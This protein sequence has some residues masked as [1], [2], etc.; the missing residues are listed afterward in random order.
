MGRESNSFLPRFSVTR[1]ITVLMGL[2]A[3]LVVGF[4]AFT[5]IPVELFPAGFTPKFLG[6]WTPYPNAN[7]QEV[8][9]QIAKPI[10]E[11]IRT[12]SGVRRV[13]TNSFTNGCWTF[14]EFAKGTDMDVA[15]AQLRDRV[16]RVKAELPDDVER[17]YIRKWSNDDE[18]ILWV[19][20]AQLTPMENVYAL[21]ETQIQKPLER[22]D[23]VAKIEIWGA[24]E[25]SVLIHVNQNKVKAYKINLYQ[26]IQTLRSDNFAIS[27]GRVVEGG[28]DIFVRSMGKFLS[29]E[30]IR[31]LP[32]KGT[33]IYLKDV[34]EVKY[35]VPEKRW[36]NRIDGQKAI[37][38]GVFKESTANT[39]E[40]CKILDKKFK[41]DFAN[42]PL[43][44]N[45]KIQVLFNQGDWIN[46]SVDNLQ[47]T[48]L[49]G[50]IFAFF[51]LFFF[52]RRVRMT[53][54]VNVAI[55]LSLLVTLIF[56]YF[57]GWTL[58][59]ITMMGL[60]I[61][62]GMVVDNSIVVVENIYRRRA[63]GMSI[64]NAAISGASEVGLA[65][66]MATL[67]TVVVFLPLILMNGD[68]DFTFFML[69]IGMPVVIALLSSL[70]VAM[71]FI[72][73]GATKIE[74]TRE[75]KE[76]KILVWTNKMY[77]RT[78]D[79]TM[80]H[81][82]ET[83][84][85]LLI[86]LF[87]MMY[88]K[89]NA[90]YTNDS[91]GNINDIRIFFDMPANYKLS[92]AERVFDALE[93]TVWAKKE[94]YGIRTINSRYSATW[95]QMRVFLNAPPKKDWYEVAYDNVLKQFGVLPDGI[96]ERTAVVEDL[97]K[98]FPEF[99]GVEM[100]TS[101]RRMD[102]E[103]ASVSIMLYGDDTATL[104]KLSKEVE[105]RLGTIE[106]IVSIETDQDKGND[107]I[108]LYL[109]RD[110]L[111]KY[112]IA[113]NVIS[114][115]VQYA[116][117]GLPLPKYHTPD[118]EVDVQ[119]QVREEDRRN[120]SQLKNLTF[121]TASGKEIPLDAVATFNIT[122]GLGEIHREN[123][124]TYLQVKANTTKDDM[125][126]IFKKVDMVMAGFDMPYGYTW[127]KGRGFDRMNE[128]NESVVFAMFLAVTFVFIIMGILFESFVLP[129][130]VIFSMPFALVGAFWMMFITQT[131]IDFMSQIGFVILV[132]IVV[133]NAIV[134]ID[135]INRLRIEG[136][137]RMDAIIEAGR[138]RYRPILMTA[139]TT[140]GG[141]IPMAVG[142]T[143][144]IGI[145][146][147]PMGRTIIGGLLLS[148]LVSL[149]AVP[150]AYTVFDDMRTYFRRISTMY[151][152]KSDKVTQ[153]PV[154]QHE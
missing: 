95:G 61:S 152:H 27:S 116:L 138:L 23:G 51:I 99:P 113:P 38:I 82:V 28:R 15:Y 62:I 105:R 10:E 103:D 132:G 20:F 57:I 25:K 117:R 101:W 73:L 2:T 146:Y 115:T 17:L 49:W 75:V 6:V 120:L 70:A 78:L 37:G 109:K 87:S 77:R 90:K 119:I 144:M 100:R 140:I 35:D 85:I 92:D 102:G 54:I 80:H 68:E 145:P 96:M 121:F 34:A 52:L 46:E 97:K 124:K 112:G 131:P 79:W 111:K 129:L 150:W 24:D 45:F 133:N 19:S 16:D 137:S 58:N 55:P 114:G 139:F 14:I 11:H 43:L 91:S 74:S 83:F 40:L 86:T 7:P 123:G 143:T 71:I 69:R 18:P 89:D 126:D 122:K 29:L 141:L 26:V 53:F 44:S 104:T 88:A 64:L 47:R 108:H 1:P 39:V 151:L 21:A 130:S 5:Q 98:R 31:N 149:I 127:S 32:I 94:L 72:P 153:A 136:Y 81:R 8:E 22:I 110:Q 107:E 65:I 30:D 118:K 148:T 93:D 134:L 12:I 135:L 76:A 4:I 50:G 41:E 48:A 33:N 13:Q 59:L 60:M 147:A 106:E 9:E 63:E 56:I 84:I 42:N 142:N 128:G 125:K 154:T 67:T 3:L 66:T 36:R